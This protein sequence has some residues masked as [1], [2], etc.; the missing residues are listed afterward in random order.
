MRVREDVQVPVIAIGVGAVLIL[1]RQ[2]VAPRQME[3]RNRAWAKLRS[4]KR[5][6]RGDLPGVVRVNVIIGGWAILLR[7]WMLVT[8]TDF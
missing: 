8:G 7:V 1:R 5:Y 3:P 2:H 6:G 4:S